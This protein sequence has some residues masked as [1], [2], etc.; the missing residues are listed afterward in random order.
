MTSFMELTGVLDMTSLMVCIGVFEWT[1]YKV[2]YYIFVPFKLGMSLKI[3]N[4]RMDAQ[5]MVKIIYVQN[6]LNYSTTGKNFIC[7]RYSV[8]YLS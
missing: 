3:E 4:R 8:I 2:N 6:Y 7:R 5:L 1:S